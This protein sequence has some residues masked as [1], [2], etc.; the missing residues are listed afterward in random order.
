[1]WL[2][3]AV[4]EGLLHKA[5]LESLWGALMGLSRALGSEAEPLWA[6]WLVSEAVLTA[7]LGIMQ[8][9]RSRHVDQQIVSK[10]KKIS[11]NEYI[12]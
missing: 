3:E 6:P 7:L 11:K 1:M 12:Y 4:G 8:S 5:R 10:I 9:S 2:Q